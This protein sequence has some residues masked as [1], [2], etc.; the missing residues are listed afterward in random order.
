MIPQE[1]INR[2]FRN[3]CNDDERK[4]V[5]QYFEENPAE[6]DK[7]INEEDWEG[8]T[9]ENR[10]HPAISKK[11]FQTVKHNTFQ[12]R[13]LNGRTWLGIAASLVLLA[14]VAWVLLK[15]EGSAPSMVQEE[16]TEIVSTNWH[17]QVNSTHAPMTVVLPD[18]STVILS[19]KSTIRYQD[20]FENN[21]KRTI[22]LHGQ[23]LFKVAK[24][25]K[26]PFT[27]YADDVATTALGTEFTVTS[28]RESN[29]IRV[30][31]H[32]GRVVVNATDSIH[33][34]W[35]TNMYLTPGDELVY[36]K[37]TMLA[38]VKRA[39]KQEQLVKAGASFRKSGT[40]Q[41]P[42]W[43]EFNGK[44]LSEVL[45]QLSAY[46]QVDIYYYPADIRN[47]YFSARL[48]NTDSLENILHDIALLNRLS[49]EKQDSSYI[50]KKKR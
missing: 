19:P 28:F 27:V 29:E 21:D 5:L 3:E 4:R 8:F 22:L 25:A 6:W 33:K 2:F 9:T 46:Y 45:D 14:G 42:D 10:L 13:R 17:E 20:D 30:V 41:K 24:D 34:K 1:L 31:L 44:N 39:K 40:I 37:Q 15:Q 12:Q 7:Y 23:A 11:I 18:G 36:N 49:I 35:K 48:R 26:R 43:Y 16:T 38:T 50:I 47:K 32:E